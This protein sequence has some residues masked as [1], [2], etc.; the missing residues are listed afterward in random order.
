MS[1]YKQI[2]GTIVRFPCSR[3]TL[4]SL[5][6]AKLVYTYHIGVKLML[7]HIFLTKQLIVKRQP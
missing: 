5:E 7:A 1:A 4:Y 3:Q 6:T 2:I